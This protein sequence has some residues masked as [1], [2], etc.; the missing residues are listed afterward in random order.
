MWGEV[1]Y[2]EQGR[3]TSYVAGNKFDCPIKSG[4]FAIC[5]IMSKIS[6]SKNCLLT[7]MKCQPKK[8]PKLFVHF[9]YFRDCS[10][11]YIS[12]SFVPITSQEF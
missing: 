10:R 2:T 11:S 12:L 1:V 3:P 4:H 7:I 6:D 5:S 9:E 8:K